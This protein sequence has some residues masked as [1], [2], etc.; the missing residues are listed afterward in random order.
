MVRKSLYIAIPYIIGFLTAYFLHDSNYI[1]I[2]VLVSLVIFGVLIFIIKLGLKPSIL[3]ETSFLVGLI[4]FSNYMITHVDS[5]NIYEDTVVDFT[6]NIIEVTEYTDMSSYV[7][8]GNIN[9]HRVKLSLY[10]NTLD[11]S[12][13]DSITLTGTVNKITG[14][15]L[16]DSEQYY[17][18]KGIYL[19]VS[20]FSTLDITHNSN[21]ILNLVRNLQDYRNTIIDIFKLNMSKKSSSLLTA[22]LFGDKSDLSKDDKNSLIRSGLGSL[23]AVSGFHLAVLTSV[24]NLLLRILD[25]HDIS[26]PRIV[27]FLIYESFMIMFIT[28]VD[29]PISAVRT[30]IMLSISN[31]AM[32]IFRKLDTLTTLTT[33]SVI[34][35][36]IE[37]YLIG[38]VSFLLSVMGVFGIGVLSPYITK[39]L[40][41]P[42]FIK[43]IL[44]I[45]IT[46]MCTLVISSIF[47]DEVSI[48][49]PISNIVCV[50]LCEISLICGFLIFILGGK[51]TFLTKIILFIADISCRGMVYIC[52]IFSKISWGNVPTGY[53]ILIYILI[54]CAIMCILSYGIFKDVKRLIII[55]LESI[56]IFIISLSVVKCVEDNTLKISIMGNSKYQVMIIS[57]HNDVNIIDFSKNYNTSTYVQKYLKQY[58]NNKI[59]SITF[60][61]KAYQSMV[62]YDIQLKDYSVNTINVPM[63][64]NIRTD[65][66]ILGTSPIQQNLTDSKLVYYYGDFIITVYDNKSFEISSNGM[67]DYFSSQSINTTLEYYNNG[68]FTIK[69]LKQ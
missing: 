11:C 54:I 66:T 23:I 64:T 33:T 31:I 65:C 42:K 49:A 37:P 18:S 45:V 43:G 39:D 51:I 21:M 10:T 1:Y 15:Y 8:D 14:N 36:S 19:E 20:E 68:Q 24:L 38:N 12:Y 22:I 2:S 35:I 61:K 62:M 60:F 6:G 7:L 50:P 47:F 57:Y 16:F 55:M 26:P 40:N 3:C 29:F 30:F 69:E 17:N 13:G 41:I 48:L 56:L 5:L 58:G 52:G 28:V 25:K 59:S 44:S 63:G 53:S 9:Q 32:L 67:V 34:M 46:T 27:K 4:V